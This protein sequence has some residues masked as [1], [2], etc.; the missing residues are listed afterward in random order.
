MDVKFPDKKRYV[1]LEWPLTETRKSLFTKAFMTSSE[2]LL[3]SFQNEDKTMQ[4]VG[5]LQL[6]TVHLI[7][8]GS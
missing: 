7:N 1:T 4:H 5:K 6:T 8:V 2:V 3:V